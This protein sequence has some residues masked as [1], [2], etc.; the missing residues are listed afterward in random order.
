MAGKSILAILAIAI[1]ASLVTCDAEYEESS[2][3]MAGMTKVAAANPVSTARPQASESDA[4]PKPTMITGDGLQER[5]D[6]QEASEA[7]TTKRI[8]NTDE[9]G[10]RTPNLV[11]TQTAVI[12]SR[13]SD[14]QEESGTMQKF[15]ITPDLCRDDD[16]PQCTELRLGDDYLTTSM[17]RKGHLY[18]CNEK[19]PNAPGANPTKM[20]W[21][22]FANNTWNLLRKLW[23]PQG[24][25]QLGEGAYTETV[26]ESSRHITVNNLPLDGM[27]GDWPMTNYPQLTVID[28]NPGVPVAR[29][30]EFS[31]PVS[32]SIATDPTCVSLGP[33]G[34]TKNG[35]VI[36]SAVDGRGE[37]AVAREIL[38]V[39]GGHPA[40]NDY[41][42]HFI[43]E[44]LDN[45]ELE[46]GHSG[47][48]GY[49]NDGFPLY[50]YKGQGGIEMSNEDLDLC[51]G[52]AHGILGY[53]YHATLEY[54]YTIGCYRGD[55][56]ANS[57]ISA[58]VSGQSRPPPAGRPRR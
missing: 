12:G 38:D 47:V 18:S 46:D 26:V 22:D 7:A 16:G 10:G 30:F 37:D 31:Y 20:T 58:Q 53:H 35:V 6:E 9:S 39:F 43:P 28:R 44:R 11:P 41:H 56:N 34:V 54:P 25:S 24:T 19:N 42:Y 57:S 36:Y 40:R 14:S 50:G 1:I 55:A 4:A 3:G 29:T 27:I 33:V 49:I 15:I 23:V 52:H 13:G 2:N 48:V 17:P 5:S 45:E 21:I 51:H 8:A 32:P